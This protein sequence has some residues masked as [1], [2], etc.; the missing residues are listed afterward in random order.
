MLLWGCVD[1]K[2]LWIFRLYYY[3]FC[4]YRTFSFFN[5]LFPLKYEMWHTLVY[6]CF[7][8]FVEVFY[9]FFSWTWFGYICLK[10]CKYSIMNFD[11]YQCNP[12]CYLILHCYVTLFL[13]K[14]SYAISTFCSPYRYN[15]YSFLPS[16]VYPFLR[17]SLT[18][19]I[20]H[21][22]LDILD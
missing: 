15:R 22:M 16:I 3:F 9:F 21:F 1:D 12:F 4:H 2:N 20:S 8:G 18:P 11:V 6:C 19:R 14:E 7:Q 10:Y 17:A 5:S 13:D